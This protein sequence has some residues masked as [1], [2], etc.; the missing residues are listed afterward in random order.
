MVAQ[1]TT[2]DDCG[3][4]LQPRRTEVDVAGDRAVVLVW[5]HL[6]RIW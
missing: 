2:S 1:H 4:A 6:E 5:R 3:L